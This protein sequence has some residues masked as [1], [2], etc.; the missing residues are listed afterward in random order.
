MKKS[1]AENALELDEF[2]MAI[3]G[4]QCYQVTE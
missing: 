2:I 1:I 4:L 3:R